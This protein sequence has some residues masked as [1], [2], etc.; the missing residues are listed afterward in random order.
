MKESAYHPIEAKFKQDANDKFY[1]GTRF[2]SLP[3]EQAQ[4]RTPAHVG[5]RTSA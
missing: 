3:G 4:A 1:E 5:V 2:I